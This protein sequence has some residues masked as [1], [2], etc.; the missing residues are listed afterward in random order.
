MFSDIGGN[1]PPNSE[2]CIDINGKS[3][4][5]EIVLGGDMK[6]IQLVLGLNGSIGVYACPWCWNRR[7]MGYK[8]DHYIKDPNKRTILENTALSDGKKISLASKKNRL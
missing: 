4:P 3:I 8:R 7:T 6:F 5:L 1:Q 2:E